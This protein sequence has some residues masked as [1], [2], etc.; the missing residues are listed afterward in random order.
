MKRLHQ[1]DDCLIAK[2]HDI[3]Q[4]VVDKSRIIPIIWFESFYPV[5]VNG[6]TTAYT[7]EELDDEIPS[8]FV[9]F[10][11]DRIQGFFILSFVG[12]NIK[13]EENE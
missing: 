11:L 12:K 1:K 3:M 7:Y 8:I 10:A 4:R 6:R 9:V 2:K 5:T 13:R